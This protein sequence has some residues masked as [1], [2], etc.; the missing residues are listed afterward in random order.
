M[1][2]ILGADQ[3][4]EEKEEERAMTLKEAI[5][6]VFAGI[7]FISMVVA[8][9]IAE[10]LMGAAAALAGIALVMCAPFLIHVNRIPYHD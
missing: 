8:I 10:N 4:E 2:Q 3:Y 1:C 9:M 6:A 5:M 7:G